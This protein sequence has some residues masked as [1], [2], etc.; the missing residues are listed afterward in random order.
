M[1]VVAAAAVLAAGAVASAAVYPPGSISLPTR[2][3]AVFGLGYAV[4]ALTPTVLVLA[5]AFLPAV[6]LAA[7]VVV[8]AGLAVAARRRCPPRALVADLRSQLRADTVALAAGGVVVAAIAVA[9]LGVA[10][11]PIHGA[12]RYWADGLELADVGHIPAATLQWGAF[13]PPT[14]SKIV[15]NAF[16]GELS[17][18]FAA[19]PFA[20]MATGL[21]LAVVGYSAGLWAL[22]W[23]LGLRRAAPLLPV[24]GV[25]AAHLPLGVALNAGSIAKLTFFQD[26]D[27]G[28]AVAVIAAAMAIPALRGAGGRA[29]PVAAGL[30]LAA[31]ALTHAIPAGVMTVLLVAYAALMLVRR[32]RRRQTAIAAAVTLATAAV[33]GVALLA[34]AGGDIGLEGGTGGNAYVLFD[35][36]FDPTAY[37]DN[38]FLLPRPK[39]QARWYEAPTTTLRELVGGAIERTPAWLGGS[40]PSCAALRPPSRRGG[41]RRSFGSP[42]WP[43]PPWRRSSSRWRWSSRIGSRTTFRPR[44]A[45]AGS[46]STPRSP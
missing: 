5:H 9:R 30:V 2:L 28:R 26:E 6:T 15:G 31:G 32:D 7:L 42:C 19:H 39:S 10:I 1:A 35:G 29:A 16:T 33:A 4:A 13:H 20:G 17:F 18:V 3:A 27:M 21:W 25:A 14:V 24:L 23:E 38:L 11:D 41:G 45:S 22:G 40:W 36:R 34:F 43:R 8:V 46:S 12:W 44:S 37:A